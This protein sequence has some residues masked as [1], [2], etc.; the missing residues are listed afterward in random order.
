MAKYIKV[1]MANIS[2]M[3]KPERRG[4][5]RKLSGNQ[6]GYTLFELVIVLLCVAI[7]ALL[8]ILFRS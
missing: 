6:S 7:L 3:I 1:H 5:M 4:E 2:V 8:A